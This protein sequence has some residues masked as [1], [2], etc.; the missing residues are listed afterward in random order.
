MR[1]EGEKGRGKGGGGSG[2]RREE[3]R[4]AMVLAPTFVNRH[5][6]GEW[7]IACLKWSGAVLPRTHLEEWHTLWASQLLKQ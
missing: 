4:M 1:R 3:R 2:G 6:H 5:V 7:H